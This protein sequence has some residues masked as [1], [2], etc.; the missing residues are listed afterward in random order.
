MEMEKR[1]NEHTGGVL[2]EERE[3]K[4]GKKHQALGDLNQVFYQLNQENLDCEIFVNWMSNM[5]QSYFHIHANLTQVD[6]KP[7]DEREKPSRKSEI[8]GVQ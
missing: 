3:C 6:P 8:K 2:K 4:I 5:P 7:K 1:E